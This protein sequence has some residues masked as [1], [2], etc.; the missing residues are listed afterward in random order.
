MNNKQ[1][2]NVSTFAKTNQ[3]VLKEV[4]PH[5]ARELGEA[6]AE[7]EEEG[8]PEVVGSHGGVGR[9]VQLGLVHKTSCRLSLEV[10]L[11]IGSPVDPAVGPV[12]K[13]LVF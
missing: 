13:H 6:E 12:E 9:G 2:N 8:Q 7:C 3:A 4:P 11:H 5:T 1:T 10:L